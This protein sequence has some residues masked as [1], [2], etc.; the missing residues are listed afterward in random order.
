[1]LLFSTLR[2]SG[3]SQLSLD[4]GFVELLDRV[5]KH[6][7]PKPTKILIFSAWLF[8]M[9][10]FVNGIFGY[11]V[12]PLLKV[13]P[14]VWTALSWMDYFR[15]GL[16]ILIGV[17]TFSSLLEA[18]RM[19]LLR[20]E[21]EGATGRADELLDNVSA[22]SRKVR[23]EADENL[24]DAKRLVQDAGQNV[25]RARELQR[26]A[27]ML[28][29]DMYAIGSAKEV[30]SDEMLAEFRGLLDSFEEATAKLDHPGGDQDRSE[31]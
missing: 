12:Q 26:A 22:F 10:F 9:A 29:E 1:M 25:E 27:Q 21:F 3:G 31:A 23:R 13:G 14:N 24:E 2:R 6:I 15:I 11:V 19:K 17:S 7:G 4:L 5:E 20:A 30:M 18:Y 28:A 8:A 16:T